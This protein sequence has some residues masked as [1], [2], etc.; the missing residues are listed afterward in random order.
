[1]SLNVFAG[2]LRLQFKVETYMVA[3]TVNYHVVVYSTFAGCTPKPHER[4]IVGG[5]YGDQADWCI[6]NMGVFDCQTT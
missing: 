1:M 4:L 2:K 6:E 5:A 3:I